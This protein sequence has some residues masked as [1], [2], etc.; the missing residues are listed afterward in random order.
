MALEAS[1][2]NDGSILQATRQV[3]GPNDTVKFVITLPSG[4]EFTSEYFQNDRKREALHAWLPAVRQQVVGESEEA[5]NEAKR[6]YFEKQARE[7]R[8]ADMQ[9]KPDLIV[10][11]DPLSFSHEPLVLPRSAELVPEDAL[12]HAKRMVASALQSKGLA[13]AAHV[14]ASETLADAEKNLRR[15][16]AVLHVLELPEADSQE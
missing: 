14:K 8:D 9:P 6:A 15:W 2:L 13:L 1:D 12:S 16:T 5:E 11:A 4:R 7:K 10:S 3:G